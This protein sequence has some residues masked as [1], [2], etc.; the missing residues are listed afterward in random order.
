MGIRID[1]LP[2]AFAA[3][4]EHILPAMKD[5][6]TVGLTVDQIREL[7]TQLIIDEQ[8]GGEEDF[9]TVVAD[10]LALKAPLLS[11]E[12]TG[13]PT[14]PTQVSGNRT[15]RLS[16]TAFVGGEIDAAGVGQCRLTL[17]GGNLLLSRCGGRWLTINGKREEIPSAGVS[18]SATGFTAATNYLIAAY[19]NAGVMTL[20]RLDMATYFYAADTSS[21]MP[22]KKTISGGAI[23]PTRTIVG[24][25]RAV[26]GPAFVD[27]AA[28]R[29]VL[30]YFNRRSIGGQKGF[31]S[32][33]STS[34]ASYVE[35][36]AE[37]RT[38]ILTWDDDAVSIALSAAVRNSS[39]GRGTVCSLAIDGT[40]PEAIEGYS[41]SAG[42]SYDGMIALMLQKSGLSAGYHYVTAVGKT[43]GSGTS[44]WRGASATFGRSVISVGIRG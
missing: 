12:L 9:A 19:M 30:S 1:A 6:A 14:A 8:L 29:F 40:T 2:A 10:A 24:M 42:A 33:R 21:G 39:S 22:V 13:D 34:S 41:V 31:T 37:I 28:Q 32:D 11:P 38:E 23:D 18:L 35:I 44:S 17:S 27:T 20:E 5:N 43:D 26:T 25:V 16:T 3:T 36:D 7:I 15:T 4:L